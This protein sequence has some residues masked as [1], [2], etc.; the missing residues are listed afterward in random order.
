MSHSSLRDRT[1]P[2]RVIVDGT[3]ITAEPS[4]ARTRLLSLYAAAAQRAGLEVTVLTVPDAG[5]DDQ[6]A[7]GGCLVR[8]ARRVRPM[9]RLLGALHPGIRAAASGGYDLIAA[10]TLPLPA[11]KAIPLVLTV[12]DLRFVDRRFASLM[13]RVW[14]RF[15][16]RRNL[17]RASAVVTVSAVTATALTRRG[18]CP[19]DKTFVV[20]NAPAPRAALP[21]ARRREILD[22]YRITQPF[23]VCVGRVERRKNIA[24]LL[25][26][27]DEFLRQSG[28]GVLLVLAGSFEGRSGREIVNRARTSRGV[29]FTGVVTEEAK[30]ALLQESIALVQPSLLEGFGLPL[31]EAM[32]ARAPIACS[33]IPAHREVAGA[34]ALYFDP[35]DRSAMARALDLLAREIELRDRL[36]AAG[37]ARCAAYSW[38]RSA[39]RL[40]AA[41]RSIL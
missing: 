2:L 23:F 37:M 16:L 18:L 35:D 39:E 17:R 30:G 20:P 4:G 32:T 6:L 8:S 5:L 7:D 26:G 19:P 27:W 36:A 3:A 28:Q 31:L 12:H 10:E 25:D 38:D 21:R 34:A 1:A 22:R 14:V 33:S 11:E 40:E 13:R 29:V 24:A 9:Q 41:Y 15:F